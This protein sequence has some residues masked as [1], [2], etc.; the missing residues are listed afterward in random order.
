MEEKLIILDEIDAGI[1]G[2]TADYVAQ[3]I[4]QLAQHHR[5]ICITHLAQIAAIANEQLALQKVPGKH[6]III[7]IIPLEPQQ[8][9]QEI[10]RMLEVDISEI[11][12]THAEELITKYK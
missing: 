1:G 11:S 6:K 12:L 9:Q 5:I 4:Y 8:R 7:R 3:F 10:D 2:K